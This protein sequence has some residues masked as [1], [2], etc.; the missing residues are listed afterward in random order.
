MQITEEDF[1]TLIYETTDGKAASCELHPGVQVIQLPDGYNGTVRSFCAAPI[2][3]DGRLLKLRCANPGDE[4]L[5]RWV[6]LDDYR[7]ALRDKAPIDRVQ[8]PAAPSERASVM[9]TR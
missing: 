9:W 4:H 3:R 8:R 7:N 1:T 2:E 5:I 6:H